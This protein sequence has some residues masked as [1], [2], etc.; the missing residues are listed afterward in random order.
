MINFAQSFLTQ[1]HVPLFAESVAVFWSAVEFLISVLP[2]RKKAVIP[3]I[4]TVARI[5][6]PPAVLLN[7]YFCIKS[8]KVEPTCITCS[9]I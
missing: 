5:F 6:S 9:K 8:F 7:R 4:P 1:V 3:S 2:L